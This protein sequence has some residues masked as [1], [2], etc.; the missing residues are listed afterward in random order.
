MVR[1]HLK[2][3]SILVNV[4]FESTKQVFEQFHGGNQ[5]KFRVTANSLFKIVPFLP[6]GTW[7]IFKTRSR[8]SRRRC[9]PLIINYVLAADHF[10]A[11]KIIA[12]LV[13][14]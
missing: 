2:I 3:V 8:P 6:R 11:I 4:S 14:I 5:T 7:A 1:C 12:A 13:T 10:F 9:A